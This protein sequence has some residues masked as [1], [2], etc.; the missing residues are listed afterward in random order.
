MPLSESCNCVVYLRRLSLFGW[1]C[2][3][4]RDRE[5][6]EWE[7][8][9]VIWPS[10]LPFAI[11]NVPLPLPF[12]VGIICFYLKCLVSCSL[13]SPFWLRIFIWKFVW[14]PLFLTISIH[15]SNSMLTFPFS[16]FQA[17]LSFRLFATLLSLYH[18]DCQFTYT[19]IPFFFFLSV[20]QLNEAE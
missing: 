17:R 2:L 15:S 6:K 10:L 8:A 9:R 14:L 12:V 4:E 1:N 3:I 13:F 11:G 5:P 7:R 18:V 16:P 20:C 19:Q